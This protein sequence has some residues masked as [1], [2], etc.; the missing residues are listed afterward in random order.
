MKYYVPGYNDEVLYLNE[1]LKIPDNKLV[2][3]VR[4]IY[5]LDKQ[6]KI[7]KIISFN[8]KNYRHE[9]MQILSNNTLELH[10][11]YI[12]SEIGYFHIT[13]EKELIKDNKDIIYEE[14]C[15]YA[16]SVVI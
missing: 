3:L 11:H 15:P 16:I 6:Y 10:N 7:E 13:F 2:E 1:E 4:K 14:Y 9:L 5:F 12:N 8:N